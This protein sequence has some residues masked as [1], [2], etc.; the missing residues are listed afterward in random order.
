MLHRALRPPI[1]VVAALALA[2]TSLQVS[3]Y[4]FTTI[5]QPG[6]EY[7]ALWSITNSGT[8]VGTSIL[9][10]GNSRSFRYDLRKGTSDEL[11]AGPGGLVF[12]ALGINLPG[13]IVGPLFDGMNNQG[14][15]LDKKGQFSTFT[16][17]GFANTVPRAVSTT[18]LVSGYAVS[19]SGDRWT[20]FLYDPASGNVTEVFP[21]SLQVIPQGMNARGQ[22]VGSV[23]LLDGEAYPGS[24]IG[25]Y[26]FLREPDGAI[27]LFRVNGL[28]TRARGISDNGVVAGQVINPATGEAR[29]YAVAAPSGGEY[30]ALDGIEL[31]GYPGAVATFPQAIDNQGRIV[32]SWVDADGFTKGFLAEPSV[33]GK[34]K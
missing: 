8:A 13:T 27:T 28:P 26:G 34:A 14:A 4:D 23:F 11:P 5:E 1:G 9:A 24:P 17:P 12:S 22:L 6:A 2:G 15:I 16:I 25:Q 33:K 20:G 10:D 29:G 18:G 3:A 7:S 32:G 31:F 21:D 19:D 30:Q